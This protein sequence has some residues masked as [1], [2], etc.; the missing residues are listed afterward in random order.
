LWLSGGSY[1]INESRSRIGQGKLVILV[2]RGA[3]VPDRYQS[4]G[5]VVE[6]LEDP[7]EGIE[8][9]LPVE[10]GYITLNIISAG[11]L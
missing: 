9:E 7:V 6:G 5:S 10:T 1:L 2:A 11:K 8:H 4:S 3:R